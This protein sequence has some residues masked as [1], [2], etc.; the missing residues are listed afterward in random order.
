MTEDVL[1]TIKGYHNIDGEDQEPVVTQ[2]RG[3]YAFRNGHHF[4]RFEEE[5]GEGQGTAK[6]LVKFGGKYLC[7]TRHG[8]YSTRMEFEEGKRKLTKY[9][10]PAGEL[11]FGVEASSIT[12]EED[13]RHL[14][15]T[16]DYA[17]H[18]GENKIQDSRV[19]VTVRPYPFL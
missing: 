8:A 2:A 18:S 14:A 10:T 7:V 15:V 17:L 9:Q 16:V 12:C 1:I 11:E 4:V 6:N 13:S 3:K 5:L 19:V